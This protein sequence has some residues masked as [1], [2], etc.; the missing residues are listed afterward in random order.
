MR[1]DERYPTVVSPPEVLSA[2]E[3]TTEPQL[4][5][6][7]RDKVVHETPEGL[8][9]VEVP[10]DGVKKDGQGDLR[11]GET[12]LGSK[13]ER[14]CCGM[15][16]KTFFIL[17]GVLV[18]VLIAA[19]VGGVVGGLKSSSSSD[20]DDDAT[21]TSV[22][23][24]GPIDADER[25]MA[26]AIVTKNDKQNTQVF[27]NDLASTSIMYNRIH[28]D[29][30]SDSHNLTLD[31]AP[32]WGAPL[33]AAAHYVSSKVATQLFYITTDSSDETRIAQAVLDCGAIDSDD[34]CSVT[35][36]AIISSNLTRGVHPASKL[37]ALHLS[38]DSMRVYFQ[39]N[40]DGANLWV[41]HN[42][43]G[44]WT[45]SNL[46]G[47]V[48]E[49]SAIGASAQSKSALHVFYVS[50]S[51][52]RLAYVEYSDILGADDA[53]SIDDSPGS[54][55]SASNAFSS[56]YV[57]QYESYRVYYTNPSTGNIVSYFQNSTAPWQGNHDNRWGKSQSSIASVAWSNQVRLMYFDDDK[58]VMSAQNAST[59]SAVEDVGDS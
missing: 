26:A 31:I 58:L 1:D 5:L 40:G 57:P 36:N 12:L 29:E 9:P 54:S 51:T 20:S 35:S 3:V 18:V 23:K 4:D 47:N 42:D 37:A 10:K 14:R 55:W 32:S 34:A 21:P 39:A 25:S 8:I 11:G 28:D 27:Y 33:A 17:L 13:P 22:P 52:E 2:P 6:Q 38:N 45:G 49:G 15:K 59:W 44:E 50:N 30:G 24:T 48:L 7:G 16:R 19:I 43:N 56:V 53:K 41:L 46:V